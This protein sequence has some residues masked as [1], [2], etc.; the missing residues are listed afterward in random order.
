MNEGDIQG[1]F[2][3]HINQLAQA[4]KQLNIEYFPGW[5]CNS[6]SKISVELQKCYSICLG[7][8]FSLCLCSEWGEWRCGKKK[9]AAVPVS[10][11]LY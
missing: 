4:C 10:S 2:Y 11:D 5:R 9:I 8:F 6:E 7:F 1:L 3:I